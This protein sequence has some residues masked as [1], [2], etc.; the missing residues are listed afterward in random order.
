MS[1]Q[2]GHN[3]S[4]VFPPAPHA[5]YKFW[6]IWCPLA[7]NHLLGYDL[8]RKVEAQYDPE[9]NGKEME[10]ESMGPQRFSFESSAWLS[11]RGQHLPVCGF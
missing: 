5:S 10:R 6:R 7:W 9:G 4:S 11:Q 3:G 8:Q 1:P 2:W